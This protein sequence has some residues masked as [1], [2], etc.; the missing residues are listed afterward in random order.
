MTARASSLHRLR[1]LQHAHQ[2][3][4]RAVLLLHQQLQLGLAAG[5]ASGPALLLKMWMRPWQVC[6]G[7]RVWNN[8][9]ESPA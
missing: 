5:S 7:P 2:Q 1:Q 4:V 6:A 9:S 8:C 3:L